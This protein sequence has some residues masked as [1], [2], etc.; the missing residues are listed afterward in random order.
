MTAAA[1]ESARLLS[2]GQASAAQLH[3]GAA[4]EAKQWANIN[5]TPASWKEVATQM[6]GE[7]QN[8]IKT[9]E[10]AIAAGEKAPGT[11]P[12]AIGTPAAPMPL[13]DYLK[14]QGY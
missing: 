12:P 3:Q 10:D 7:G 14:S 5:M 1:T 2:G 8:K 9:Y 13:A 11:A 6:R 4:D